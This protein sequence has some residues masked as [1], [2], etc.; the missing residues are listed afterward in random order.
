MNVLA[1]LTRPL[2][3]VPE[4]YLVGEE[5]AV[6]TVRRH[7]IELWQVAGQTLGIWALAV[8]VISGLPRNDVT[9]LFGLVI[10]AALARFLWFYAD[11]L[12]TTITVTD[13]RLFILGGIMSRRLSMLPLR[14]VTDMTLVQPLGGRLLGYGSI[15]VESAGQDQA[16][17]EI[18]HIP[19]SMSFYQAIANLVFNDSRPRS[20]QV[21]DTMSFD[22]I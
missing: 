9:N 14:K 16:L 12:R 22:Q 3:S 5:I 8:L 15:I 10:L 17:S 18:H 11:W 7:W 4:Q 2:R 1:V 19:D 13:K 6:L 21:D 20:A